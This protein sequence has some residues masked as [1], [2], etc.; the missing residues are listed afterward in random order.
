MALGRWH[1]EVGETFESD[2]YIKLTKDDYELILE[3]N[4]LKKYIDK[5]ITVQ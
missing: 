4:F 3:T 2:R 1:S 5:V